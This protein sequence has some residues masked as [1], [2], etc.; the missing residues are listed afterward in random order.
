MGIDRLFHV[1]VFHSAVGDQVHIASEQT[2]EAILKAK[3]VIQY[4]ANT[5]VVPFDEEINVAGLRA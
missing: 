4:V 1:R 5:V 3:I 2:G